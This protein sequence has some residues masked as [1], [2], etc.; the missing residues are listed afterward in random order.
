MSYKLTTLRIN[1]VIDGPPY[2]GPHTTIK[3]DRC[4]STP[5]VSYGGQ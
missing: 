1:V 5:V 4:N 2:T 3:Q